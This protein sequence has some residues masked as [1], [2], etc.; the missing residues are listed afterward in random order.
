MQAMALSMTSTL[1]ISL[2]VLFLMPYLSLCA[3]RLLIF[4]DSLDRIGV[5]T[6][7]DHHH[8]NL[9]SYDMSPGENNH[10]LPFYACILSN[11]DM[12]STVHLYGSDRMRSSNEQIVFTTQFRLPYGLVYHYA[13]FGPPSRIMLNVG[14]WDIFPEASRGNDTNRNETHTAIVNNY[15]NLNN[16][17]DEILEV[18]RH[19]TN[20]MV[21]LRT[22]AWSW[23]FADAVIALNNNVRRIAKERNLTLYDLD[24]VVWSIY[25]YDT[26]KLF[27][28]FQDDHHPHAIILRKGVEVMLGYR[29]SA[30][31]THRGVDRNPCSISYSDDASTMKRKLTDNTCRSR[32]IIELV[33]PPTSISV[34]DMVNSHVAVGEAPVHDAIR[35]QEL[36]KKT[37]E[38]NP[39]Q[40]SFL[41]WQRS[42]YSSNTSDFAAEI[43]TRHRYVNLT[44]NFL[45][46]HFLS[47]GDIFFMP[48]EVFSSIAAD[49]LVVPGRFD[50]VII[51][52]L[53]QHFPLTLML[54][55][56]R[57]QVTNCPTYYVLFRH[58]GYIEVDESFYNRL[59]VQS[60]RS[61][62]LSSFS[63][64]P[65]LH[66]NHNPSITRFFR[67]EGVV[68]K[69][70]SNSKI[71]TVIDG[72]IR[73]FE[74]TGVFLKRG[75]QTNS[76]FNLPARNAEYNVILGVFS[77]GPPLM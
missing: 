16:R 51:D 5:M 34:T 40:L 47:F 75:H 41:D 61:F 20:I 65:P 42:N 13:N 29:Y 52:L 46:T 2:V 19:D 11:G 71:M 12:V 57:I 45:H 48:S 21:G 30:F 37:P 77:R 10:E 28:I 1:I 23:N 8:G 62:S 32:Y 33:H 27:R 76:V 69:L 3:E 64:A 55:A 4:G 74:S 73:E 70:F 6:F 50:E 25:N 68:F 53:S 66:I 35:H 54:P 24:L 7:C 17:L 72:Q 56:V 60:S 43:W 15:A 38:I 18:I 31:Y 67:N 49:A 59:N 44:E 26:T 39:M 22:T 58:A 9:M 63:L 36:I 14:L